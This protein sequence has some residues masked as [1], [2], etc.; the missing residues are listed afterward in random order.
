MPQSPRSNGPKRRGEVMRLCVGET[1]FTAAW[2]LR[3]GCGN[4]EV[5]AAMYC[6]GGEEWGVH[7]PFYVW[8]RGKHTERERERERESVCVCVCVC[9]RESLGFT[10]PL[11]PSQVK[12]TTNSSASAYSTSCG[13][14]IGDRGSDPAITGV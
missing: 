11:T 13:S 8:V 4:K 3:Y 5:R 7:P 12:R 10:H 1:K 14:R 9:E 2:K 6:R